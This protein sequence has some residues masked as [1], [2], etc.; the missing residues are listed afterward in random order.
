MELQKRIDEFRSRGVPV[1]AIAQEDTDLETFARMLKPF[2]EEGP[3][4]ELLCDVG[5]R[6]TERFDRTTT[7]LLGEDRRVVEV[8]PALIH[9]RPSWTAVLNRID[10]RAA[11]ESVDPW[12]KSFE[13]PLA[14]DTSRFHLEPLAPRHVDVDY[15]ALMGSRAHLRETLGWGDWPRDDFTL[16]ENRRDLERHWRE[17]EN[18]EGYA[19]TVLSPDRSRCLG[20]VYIVKPPLRGKDAAM[21]AYWTIEPELANDLDRALAGALIDWLEREWPFERVAFPTRASNARGVEIAESLGLRPAGAELDELKSAR[22]DAKLY[23]WRRS[24]PPE[25]D[26]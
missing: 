23:V 3:S 24:P 14:L 8:F 18:R 25:G 9:E 4:F 13:P 7:Y 6:Q 21:L 11:Q 2:G 22:P 20:C 15:A 10:A 16:D 26:R 17:F 1:F 19:Y 12:S 5:R